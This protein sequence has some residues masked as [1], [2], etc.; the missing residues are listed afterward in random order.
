M[1]SSKTS[2]N[3]LDSKLNF[4]THVD[5]QNQRVQWTSRTYK[6]LE[7]NVPRNT[8]LSIYNSLIRHL[9]DYLHDKTK[10]WKFQNKIEKVLYQACLAITA[11]IPATPRETFIIS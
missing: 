10:Q 9:F 3:W 11:A 6:K 4:N 1:S 7:V 8:L 5:Q 2:R